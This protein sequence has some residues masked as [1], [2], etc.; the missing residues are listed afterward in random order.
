MDGQTEFPPPDTEQALAL[1]DDSIAVERGAVARIEA[2]L[3][4][5]KAALSRLEDSRRALVRART[6]RERATKA[7]TAAQRA[8]RGNMTRVADLLHHNGPTAKAGLTKLLQ[9]N[10][11][12]VHYALLALVEEGKVRKTGERVHG[13]N[14]YE[15]VS[16]TAGR[17]GVTRPGDRR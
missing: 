13:S 1:L 16:K 10:D 12:T 7:K 9:I 17:R 2:S 6:P 11:G 3:R 14:V 4:E 5:H 15:Y 8:G